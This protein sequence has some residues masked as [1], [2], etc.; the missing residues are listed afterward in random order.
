VGLLRALLDGGFQGTLNL[1]THYQRPDKNKE[2]ATRE[3]L[4]GL[5]QAIENV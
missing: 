2:L 1:E 4:M 3:S 5:L